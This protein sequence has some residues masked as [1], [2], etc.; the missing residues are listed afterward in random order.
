MFLNRIYAFRNP[1]YE[2][3]RKM[4]QNWSRLNRNIPKMHELNA[5]ASIIEMNTQLHVI[6]NDKNMI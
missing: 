5:L 3:N 6:H 4:S 2:N 1:N